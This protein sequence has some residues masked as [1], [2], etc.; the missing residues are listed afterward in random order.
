MVGVGREL[1]GGDDVDGQ[2]DL[3]A[4]GLGLLEVA[5]D[6]VELVLLEQ[7]RADLVALGLEEGEHH[8]AADEQPVDR[9]DQ[10]VDDAELVGD[11]RAAE[12][13][14]VGPVGL[15]GEPA[16]DLGLGQRPGRRPRAAAAAARRRRW[17]ACGAR[18]RSRRRRTRRRAR[19]AGRRTRRARRRPCSS[20]PALKRR[21]SQQRDVAVA[22]PVDRGPGALADRVGGELDRP[23]EHLGQPLRRPARGCTSRPAGPWA[24][25]GGR[26]R[27]PGRRGRRGRRWSARWPGCGRRR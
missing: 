24:G 5:A 19:R 2:H 11:L 17:R 1:G 6:G 21:F 7:A 4:L 10:V 23:A 25:R 22:E 13:D 27:R 9:A 16:E 14:D 3:D 8:A 26:T 18:R 20:S 12:H 15:A